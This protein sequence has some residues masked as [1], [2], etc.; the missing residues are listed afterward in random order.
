LS[1]VRCQKEVRQ[2]RTANGGGGRGSFQISVFRVQLRQEEE[3]T[4]ADY[5]D[6]ADYL[7]GFLRGGGRR[8]EIHMD[9]QDGPDRDLEVL[10]FEL[11]DIRKR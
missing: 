5:A 2:K 6:Y 3:K 11:S 8:E 7:R 10:S 9:L 1:D 4:S